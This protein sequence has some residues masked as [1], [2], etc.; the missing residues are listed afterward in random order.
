M[1]Q[2]RIPTGISALDSAMSGGITAGDSVL[3][4]A[5]NSIDGAR[6]MQTLL[7]KLR[8]ENKKAV[9]ITSKKSAEALAAEFKERFGNK[10]G[11]NA[12]IF[13][14]GI[15]DEEAFYQVTDKIAS[16]LSGHCVFLDS[17]TSYIPF[18][19]L[20]FALFMQNLNK[21][22]REFAE[23]NITCIFLVSAGAFTKEHEACFTDLFSHIWR[24][25]QEPAEL[26][27]KRTLSVESIS[28]DAALS[29][30]EELQLSASLSP[31][32][33]LLLSHLRKIR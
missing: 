23:K 12:C 3:L 8:R 19:E 20:N 6:L 11:M 7:L 22:M 16:D 1:T 17:L 2:S 26:R 21:A 13:D 15:P 31:D 27:L 24:L 10:T 30:R 28:Q 32:G 29:P 18:A 9:Y 14:A 33:T 5:E 4:I 25:T